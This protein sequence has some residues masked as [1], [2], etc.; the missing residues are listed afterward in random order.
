MLGDIIPGGQTADDA[1][2]EEEVLA[3]VEEERRVPTFGERLDTR[4][5]DEELAAEEEAED[6]EITYFPII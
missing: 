6:D 5:T 2:A 1:R 4:P 3:Q